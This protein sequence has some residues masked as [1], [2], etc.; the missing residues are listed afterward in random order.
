[1]KGVI[2][3]SVLLACAGLS[4]AKDIPRLRE[5]P[6]RPTVSSN[7]LGS[8]VMEG[9]ERVAGYFR[10]NRTYAGECLALIDRVTMIMVFHGIEEPVATS[11]SDRYSVGIGV[12]I[13]GHMRVVGC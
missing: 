3:A 10:L 7:G 8:V 2:A 12:C 13:C 11:S 4:L 1:M 9:P 6:W 5:T